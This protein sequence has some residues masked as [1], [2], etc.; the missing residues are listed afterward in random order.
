LSDNV[1]TLGNVTRTDLPVDRVLEAAKGKIEGGVVL[2]GWDKDGELYFA[3]SIADGGE[4]V[5]LMEKAK[6]ALLDAAVD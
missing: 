6:L 5:W 1:I 2:L 4:V 3:S